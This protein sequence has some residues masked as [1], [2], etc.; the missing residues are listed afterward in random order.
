MVVGQDIQEIKR[1]HSEVL[2]SFVKAHSKELIINN[3]ENILGVLCE[4]NMSRY[5]NNRNPLAMVNCRGMKF[6]QYDITQEEQKFVYE[7]VLKISNQKLRK[8]NL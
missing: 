8:D 7:F 5:I 1:S 4:L 3:R 2:T 6:L